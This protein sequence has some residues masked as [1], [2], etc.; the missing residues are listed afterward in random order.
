M[1]SA[2]K[3]L[4][5][6]VNYPFL[7]RKRLGH[8]ISHIIRHSSPSMNYLSISKP[9]LLLRINDDR[10][11]LGCKASARGQFPIRVDQNRGD[12][13]HCDRQLQQR[14]SDLARRCDA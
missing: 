12:R 1:M 7:S 8:C 3:E 9:W 5:F 14:R 10:A 13:S 4:S 2:D 6:S 11:I